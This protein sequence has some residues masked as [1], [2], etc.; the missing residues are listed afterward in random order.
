M[1]FATGVAKQVV[2][3]EEVTENVNPVTGGQTLRRVSSDLTLNKDSYQSNEIL[4]SQQL[5]DARHGVRRPQG[6]FAGQISPGSFT[7]FWQGI[8]RNDFATGAVMA[9]I[10][11]ALNTSAKTF[12]ISPGG[13]DAGGLKKEDVI[14]FSG[15]GSPNAALNGVRMR[16][17]SLT[18]TVITTRDL[19]AGLTTGS[20]VGVTIT[21][22]GSKLFMPPSGATFKSYTVEHWFGDVSKSEAFTGVKF[23]QTS[24]ALPPT[25]LVTF[26]SQMQGMN[27]TP[28]TSR[29]L[30][31]PAAQTSSSALA[32]VNG[33]LSLNGSDLGI[34]TGMTMQLA[35]RLGADP[36]VGSNIVPHIF[37][38][39]FGVTGSLTVL[40]Q[41]TTISDLFLNET[42]FSTSLMLYS[43]ASAASEF[44][45]FTLPRMKLMSNQKSD[46]DMALIQSFNFTALENVDDSRF[47]LSTI[48]VQDSLVS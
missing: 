36:V 39:T 46:G 26:S 16:I 35:G 14:V 27:M 2:I 7:D 4:V 9:T 1:A 13:F 28:A 5:R 24:I 3:A 12:T 18:D 47:D 15:V 22:V 42:E 23:G 48:I 43:G 21:V 31:S 25:G 30:T 32:A 29:Q 40:F 34:V 38:G 11:V 6:T 33:V 44:M 20:L 41:D 37:T 8:L 19:P 45:R 10:T 17:N